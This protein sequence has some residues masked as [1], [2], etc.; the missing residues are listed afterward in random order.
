ME[1]GRDQADTGAV[2]VSSLS[3]C[4]RCRIKTRLTVSLLRGSI[5]LLA[6]LL[7]VFLVVFLLIFLL[8][9]LVIFLLVLLLVL[10]VL[11][12]VLL[13]ILLLI[14]V[15]AFG[16]QGVLGIILGLLLGLFLAIFIFGVLRLSYELCQTLSSSLPQRENG[17]FMLIYSRVVTFRKGVNYLQISQGD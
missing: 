1:R 10:L 6:I 13:L 17:T 7:L 12:V 9:L 16:F 5:S 11:L 4:H 14:L 2:P 3:S 15:V 8:V